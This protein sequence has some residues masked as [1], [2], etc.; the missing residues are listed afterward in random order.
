MRAT[1]ILLAFVLLPLVS[2]AN[3]YCQPPEVPPA[4]SPPSFVELVSDAA[5]V[6]D[7]L[8]GSM[9]CGYVNGGTWYLKTGL[10]GPPNALVWEFH[11]EACPPAVDQGFIWI[12]RPWGNLNVSLVSSGGWGQE[13]AVTVEFGEDI[14]IEGLTSIGLRATGG[15][16]GYGVV[17][18]AQGAVQG[19]PGHV[20][21]APG[22]W[23][24]LLDRDVAFCVTY[25]QPIPVDESTWGDVKIDYR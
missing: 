13:W 20:R 11:Y 25:D 17:Q 9:E 6:A 4:G 16:G 10:A 5:A 3:E 12:T 7:D 1:A 24:S 23:T 19:C 14:H 22:P 15:P 2:Y 21:P 18:T 8:M